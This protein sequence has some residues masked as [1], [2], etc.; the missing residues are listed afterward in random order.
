MFSSLIGSEAFDIVVLRCLRVVCFG[1]LLNPI[2]SSPIEKTGFGRETDFLVISASISPESITGARLGGVETLQLDNLRTTGE[3]CKIGSTRPANGDADGEGVRFIFVGEGDVEDLLPSVLERAP[4]R[5]PV[6]DVIRRLS[7][8]DGSEEV[9]WERG[10]SP[11]E[12][13]ENGDIRLF[14]D[15]LRK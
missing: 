15:E 5:V 13:T 10:E 14:G 11:G 12:P 1:C 2:S 8:E 4:P 7:S 6:G 9:R 3:L